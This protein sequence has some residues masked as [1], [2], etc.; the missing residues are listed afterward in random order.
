MKLV[1]DILY[2]SCERPIRYKTWESPEKAKIF[3]VQDRPQECQ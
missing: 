3:M 2:L 1:T